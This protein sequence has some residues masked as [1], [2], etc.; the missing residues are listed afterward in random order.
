MEEREIDLISLLFHVLL[1][2]RS[3]IVAGLIG[4]MLAGGYGFYALPTSG[5]TVDEKA[6]ET[7]PADFLDLD[8]DNMNLYLRAEDSYND[9]LVYLDSLEYMKLEGENIAKTV[10]TIGV[11][12][13][14]KEDTDAIASIYCRDFVNGGYWDY[15]KDKTS[16]SG[17]DIE[18][19]VGAYS[20]ASSSPAQMYDP[21]DESA[22]YKLTTITVTATG[23]TEEE[24]K[25]LA[26][27]AVDFLTRKRDSLVRDLGDHELLVLSNNT[28]T[29]YDVS[30]M[31]GQND[32]QKG[33]Y[34]LYDEMAKRK[35][36]LTEDQ[37]KALALGEEWEPD[38]A[39]IADARSDRAGSMSTVEKLRFC[40]K[41]IMVGFCGGIF[42][43]AGLWSFLYVINNRIKTEDPIEKL[44]K[45]AVIGVIPSAG[46]K[47]R[48]FGFIDR[49]IISIRDRN[50][51]IFSVD[52]ALSL[53]VS[54]VKIQSSKDKVSKLVFIGCDLGKNVPAIPESVAEKL[55]SAG[56]NA[57]VLD[58]VL[59]D[60][61]N[62]ERLGEMDGAVIIEKAGKTLY[63]EFTKEIELLKRQQ[64]KV[65]GCVIVE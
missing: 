48:V 2:W 35:R 23:R 39:T 65:L 38:A 12:G 40:L 59:Y 52:E 49:W 44:F 60:P 11:K 56:I 64:I 42:C 41:Y 32:R 21:G 37:L 30:V 13:D 20:S 43:M 19:F 24:S 1:H 61:E 57:S 3:L 7:E 46:E 29:V 8:N 16:L 58:N 5:E 33:L 15:V 18:L 26:D 50:K 22:G 9:M 36:A 62:T 14:K 34:A 45:V 51:R 28:E 10:V 25:D 55:S 17:A 47:K 54:R 53:V 63:S 6:E 31:N 27:K 4:V